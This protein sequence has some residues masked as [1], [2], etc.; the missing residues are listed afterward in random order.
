MYDV[1]LVD[2]EKLITQGLMNIIDWENLGL[3]VREIAHN[4]EEA[5]NKFKEKA[6]DIIV[7]DISMPKLTG[8]ELISEIRKINSKTRFTILTGYDEFA[9]AK[10]AIKYGVESYI[11]KPINE[12]ELEEVMASIVR[13]L[14]YK[15]KEKNILLDKN[16]KLIQY[17]EEI[18]D[19]NFIYDMKDSISIDIYN[20]IYTVANIKFMKKEDEE[21]R[22]DMEDIV[23]GYIN[24]RYEILYKYDDQ[25]ILINSWD[26]NISRNEIIN[27]YEGI[28]E[29]LIKESKKEI[30]MSIGD[31]VFDIKD[32]RK[33]Y[34]VANDLKKYILTEG[35]NKCIYKENIRDIKEKKMNFKEEIDYINK[36]IIEKS[37][38]DLEKYIS[39]ILEKK[40][41]TP[42]NIYDFSIKIIILIDD[43][44]NEFK[45]E[46][47][48]GRDSLS[49][50]IIELCNESTRKSVKAFI[51]REIEE[52]I[53]AMYKSTV[54]YS[55]VVQQIVNIVNDRY[56]EELSLKTLAH[57][58]NI[59][60]SYLGQIFSKETGSSFSEY[61]NKTKNMK[62]KEL[63]LNTNMKI[64]DIAKAVG[65]IDTSYFYRKFKKYYGVCPSTL[66]EMKNY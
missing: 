61:L 64:N 39:E 45:L 65:Y 5:L 4:G 17:L 25:A 23:D 51:I 47:K 16:R 11:L 18:L 3:K 10:E 40:E 35:T 1:M 22:V 63:I 7:T 30:F 6:V 36:L 20:K 41:L 21:D 53:E 14:D 31:T 29:N 52:L 24:D 56:Y 38:K 59:N 62:A 9:Y 33:S 58:Y 32:I 8:L 26:K 50:T 19:E 44:S 54:K 42:K 13:S 28:K 66:R 12:E 2:D 57:Q 34:K 27:Y 48:Y 55:P 49:N 60:S 43:I 37:N 46:K 15:K